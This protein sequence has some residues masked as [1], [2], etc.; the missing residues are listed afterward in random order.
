MLS[1]PGCALTHRGARR[2]ARTPLHRS[3]RPRPSGFSV[4]LR[5]VRP[6]PP[7]GPQGRRQLLASPCRWHQPHPGADWQP[8][9]PAAAGDSQ[10]DRPRRR[11]V[12]P[13]GRGG[14]AGRRTGWPERTHPAR[15]DTAHAAPHSFYCSTPPIP[16][17]L[18][19]CSASS[20]PS[21]PHRPPPTSM[22]RA[23]SRGR[24]PLPRR[25]S[26]MRCWCERGSFTDSM[27][28]I[29]CSSRYL[30]STPAYCPGEVAC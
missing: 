4:P 16:C 5:P 7:A 2:D 1:C 18:T 23:G 15:R 14:V 6:R 29:P 25:R 26:S 22:P 3:L 10:A 9:R 27:S 13:G 30:F 20:Q 12:Q 11:F 19:S 28:K 17:D 8:W 21:R 24:D